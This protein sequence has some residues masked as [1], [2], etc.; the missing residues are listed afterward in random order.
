MSTT[1]RVSAVS[2]RPYEPVRLSK[3]VPDAMIDLLLSPPSRAVSRRPVCRCVYVTHRGLS[4]L[5]F[6][7]RARP[8]SSWSGEDGDPPLAKQRVRPLPAPSAQP[9]PDADLMMDE[10]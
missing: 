7:R 4:G 1:T 6:I 2:G 10:A 8:K 3:C 9:L 5:A